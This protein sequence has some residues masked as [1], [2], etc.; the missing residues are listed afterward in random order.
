MVLPIITYGNSAL[1]EECK[2]IAS[3]YPGLQ[4]L[5]DSMWETLRAADGCGLAAP[6]VNSSIN[7]F[8]VNS[9]DTYLYLDDESRKAYFESDMGIKE[10][11]INARI[12]YYS[13]DEY[14]T[15]Q[16]GCLSI[17][18][19]SEAV[20]RAWKITIEYCNR[21]FQPCVKTYSGYTARVIQHEYD[22]ILGKLYIDY[23]SGMRKQLL[24]GKLKRIFNKKM[25]Q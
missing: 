17:P 25:K 11:F 21:D 23:V 10:T 8:I 15:D 19:I 14:W 3:T 18:G 4:Q 5:I 9:R 22:H 7:L 1:R 6:Q 16:E 2:N 13:E 24:K 12:A 20:D